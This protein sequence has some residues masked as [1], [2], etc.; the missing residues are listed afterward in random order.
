MIAK[1]SNLN[2]VFARMS[3]K[4]SSTVCRKDIVR[5]DVSSLLGELMLAIPF[6]ANITIEQCLARFG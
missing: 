2:E 5:R 4:K 3:L 6:D 1:P